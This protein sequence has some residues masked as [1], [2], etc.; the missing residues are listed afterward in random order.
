MSGF[1]FRWAGG[2]GGDILM[3]L[4]SQNKNVYT[5]FT[6]KQLSEEG[7]MIGLGKNDKNYS[8][9]TR[10]PAGRSVQIDYKKLREDIIKIKKNKNNFVIRAFVY[11]KIFD[12]NIK[13]IIEIVDI[14]CTLEFLPFVIEA[15]IK[16]CYTRTLEKISFENNITNI[17]QQRLSVEQREKFVIW[18][19]IL[20]TLERINDKDL[21]FSITTDD[22]VHNTDK[23]VSFFNSKNIM[24]NFKDDLYKSWKNTNTKILPSLQYQKYIQQK[25]Y[26]YQDKTLSIIERYILLALSKKK[27]YFFEK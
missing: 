1:I 8:T 18:N 22:I 14:G 16:K 15:N 12:K 19:V 25:N 21:N 11:N 13:D 27:F 7:Q 23:I 26:Q 5:N 3:A 20:G 2:Q 17:L 4:I 24:I 6:P 9:L 10:L